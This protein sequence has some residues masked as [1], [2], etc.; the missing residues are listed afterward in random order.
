MSKLPQKQQ[1]TKKEARTPEN[2]QMDNPAFFVGLPHAPATL[3]HINRKSL[4]PAM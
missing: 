2:G 3:S 1:E 4:T